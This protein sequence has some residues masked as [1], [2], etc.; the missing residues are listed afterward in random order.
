MFGH[1]HAVFPSK[2]FAGIKGADIAKGTLNGVPAVMPGMWGDHLGVVD[3]VLNNDS[4]KWQVSAAKAEARPI[5]DA[6]AKKSLAAE[7]SN[8]VAV[9]KA[10][11]DATREFV[12]KPIG[13]SSDNMYSYGAGAGRPDRTGSQHGPESLC[14][15]LYSGRPGSGEAAGTLRRRAV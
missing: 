13:Q 9:L 5:Y 7:D 3:L 11:H 10:D 14:G 1:A 4:G 8:M 6:A 15:A 2:D 12:G